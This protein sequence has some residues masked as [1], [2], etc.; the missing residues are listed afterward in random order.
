M[1]ETKIFEACIVSYDWCE[2]ER[3]FTVFKEA[4]E[5]LLEIV[6]KKREEMME[7]DREHN[8]TIFKDDPCEVGQFL[9]QY[10]GVIY[11]HY[12]SE[13]NTP[14]YTKSKSIYRI[15]LDTLKVSLGEYEI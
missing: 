14:N 15:A 10:N 12:A 9:H 1:T 4:K 2:G 3:Y 13:F 7:N 11:R 6:D 8:R 5:Y